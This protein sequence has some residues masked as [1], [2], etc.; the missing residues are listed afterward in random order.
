MYEHPAGLVASARAWIRNAD[1]NP[2]QAHEF[3]A[4][5]EGYLAEALTWWA[6]LLAYPYQRKE[7]KSGANHHRNPGNVSTRVGR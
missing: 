1:E 4:R 2:A 5:A 6:A 7:I 3:L